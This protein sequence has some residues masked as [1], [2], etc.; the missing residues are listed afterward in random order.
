[1]KRSFEFLFMLFLFCI[2]R[3]NA[4]FISQGTI[5]YEVKTNMKKAIGNSSWAESM[6]DQIPAFKSSFFRLSFKRNHTQYVFDHYDDK[7]RISPF[8]R[9]NDE[10]SGWE[11]D[12]EKSTYSSNKELFGTLFSIHDTIPKIKWKLSNE[13]RV[14][15]G[16]N[17]RKATGII[18]DSVYVFAFYTDEI[19]TPG[20]PATIQGLPGMI[21]GVTIPRLYTSIIAIEVKATE[22][23]PAFI[24]L[25]ES[26]K[27][28]NRRTVIS[29]V[30]NSTKDWGSDTESKSFMEQLYWNLLL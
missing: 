4:Q 7:E 16:Y 2:Q 20:G 18:M 26:P 6:K 14:I 1:M 17:C 22:K 28:Y 19:T 27:I 30:K 5:M 10:K 9:Q 23:E 29:A 12:F 3:S 13:N 24:N 11:H 21:L 8:L 15:S 25:E